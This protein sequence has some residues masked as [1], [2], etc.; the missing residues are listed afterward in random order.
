VLFRASD[1]CESVS[2]IIEYFLK[3]KNIPIVG[4]NIDMK[5]ETIKAYCIKVCS[6][7]I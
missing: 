7:I 3:T 1:E 4:H 2:P 5:S 6:N